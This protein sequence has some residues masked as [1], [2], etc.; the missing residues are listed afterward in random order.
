MIPR[1]Y[2][3]SNATLKISCDCGATYE[4]STSIRWTR[5]RGFPVLSSR[6]VN[7]YAK[8]CFLFEIICAVFL[9]YMNEDP[10][11][12]LDKFYNGLKNYK[13]KK[14][15]KDLALVGMTVEEFW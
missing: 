8:S 6:K 5:G 14:P 1:E 7:V 12:V 10:M 11:A 9:Q 2:S 4:M 3:W 15:L 13:T